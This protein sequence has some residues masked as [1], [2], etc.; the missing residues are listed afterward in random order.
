MILVQ[1]SKFIITIIIVLTLIWALPKLD[2]SF[3]PVAKVLTL[4]AQDD[5]SNEGSLIVSGTA[6][7]FRPYCTLLYTHW[8]IGKPGKR[9]ILIPSERIEQPRNLEVTDDKVIRAFGPLRLKISMESFEKQLYVVTTH[10]C[11]NGYF[12]TIQTVVYVSP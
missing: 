6:E 11:Y 10:D 5:P 3:F 4:E 2:G 1:F 8:F 9:S 7:S 12:W